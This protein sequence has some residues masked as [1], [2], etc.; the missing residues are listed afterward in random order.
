M[1]TSTVDC[2]CEVCK[3]DLYLCSVVSSKRPGKAVC[4]EHAADLGVDPEDQIFLFSY[5]QLPQL[6]DMY[7][8]L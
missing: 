3:G 7:P 5:A 6:H 1:H 2:D 8:A 4:S